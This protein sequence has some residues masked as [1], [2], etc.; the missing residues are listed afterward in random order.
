MHVARAMVARRTEHVNTAGWPKGLGPGYKAGLRGLVMCSV[1]CPHFRWR[2]ADNCSGVVSRPAGRK[3]T[4]EISFCTS[5]FARRA[6]NEVRIER[7]SIL[8]PQAKKRFPK[9][10][11]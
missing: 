4:P 11:A 5:F 10:L 2:I 1:I 3:I 9:A 6:K 8:L 7:R